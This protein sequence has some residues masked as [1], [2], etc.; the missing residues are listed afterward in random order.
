ME[1]LRMCR[2]NLDKP[3]AAIGPTLINKHI[4]AIKEVGYFCEKL[5]LDITDFEWCWRAKKKGF[6]ILRHTRAFMEHAL[7]IGTKRIFWIEYNVPAPYRQY[8][9][10]KNSIFAILC[11]YAPV[12]MR[13][14]Y[15]FL[16]IIKALLFPIVLD[17]KISRLKYIIKGLKDGIK[18]WIFS[19]N[20]CIQE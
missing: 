13:L 12:Y 3:I 10:F 1:G 11:D 19:S 16:T 4:S 5:F 20:K 7:G 9:L 8:H 6:Y 2:D 15:L 17:N 18:Y 14:R